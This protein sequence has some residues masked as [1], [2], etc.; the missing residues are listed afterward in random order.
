VNDCAPPG[1]PGG[2][3]S[4]P[5]FALT[6]LLHYLTVMTTSRRGFLGWLSSASLVGA[7]GTPSS[8]RAAGAP[9]LD[10]ALNDDH[11]LAVSETWDMSWT[12]RMTGKYKAVFDS[13]DASDGAA[14]YR[15]VSWIEQYKEV[16]NA[17]PAEVTAV[18]V[19]RHHGFYFAMNDEFWNTYDVGK[20]LKM[21][22][23][24][25]NKWA[26]VN[27]L[28]PAAAA[29]DE[30]TKKYSLA[31]FQ[32]LGGIVLVCGWSFGGAASQ[33]AKKESLEKDAARARA[34]SMLLPGVILQPNGVFAALRAQE[35]G[36]SYINAS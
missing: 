23:A 22:D 5:A 1:F 36:C 26:K 14:V 16:Y 30:N 25:G 32:A 28:A 20:D 19:L 9:P 21:R 12:S 18:V 29:A 6:T 24:K 31:G 11:A 7:F 13:P 8:A 35:A 10:A 15:A 34:K 33:I 3:Q 17:E 27:P 4:F 2:A